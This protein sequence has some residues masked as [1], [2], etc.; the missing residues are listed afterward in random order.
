MPWCPRCGTGLSQHEIHEGYKEVKHKS[1]YLRFPIINDNRK[2]SFLVWTTTP[3]TLTS[4]IALA[5]NPDLSYVKVKQGDWTYFIIK[6]RLE[7]VLKNKGTWEI[8]DEINGRDLA[9]LN[10]S[11]KG[12]YDEL[13]SQKSVRNKKG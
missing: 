1:L 7:T 6:D 10:M 11:Y 3:W 13:Q 12:P 4:N 2:E 8:L 5:V 9:G